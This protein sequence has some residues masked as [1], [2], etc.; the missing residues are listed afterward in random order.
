[1]FTQVLLFAAFS[2][3]SYSLGKQFKSM[4]ISSHFIAIEAK[5]SGS[6][7]S[8]GDWK[9]S[10]TC[11]MPTDL[12]STVSNQCP[13]TETSST[14][15]RRQSRGNFFKT[16]VRCMPWN[17]NDVTF[18]SNQVQTGFDNDNNST[19]GLL[20]NGSDK[21]IWEK[22][23]TTCGSCGLKIRCRTRKAAFACR[24]E[25]QASVFQCMQHQSQLC[26][27][28]SIH[29]SSTVPAV[30]NSIGFALHRSHWLKNL[31]SF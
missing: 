18:Q 28:R 26:R 14:D 19:S 11:V 3:V 17:E 2:H 31:W 29:N 5:F 6:C 16:G 30:P 25:I 24:W 10:N 1:M 7:P 4:R 8:W 27:L 22:I 12:E 9:E 13:Q 21:G 20:P 23:Y 15:R